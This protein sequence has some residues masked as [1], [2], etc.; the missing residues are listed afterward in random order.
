MCILYFKD[1]YFQSF[2]S[3][4]RYTYPTRY[5]TAENDQELINILEHKIYPLYIQLCTLY[6]IM[7]NLRITFHHPIYQAAFY[8]LTSEVAGLVLGLTLS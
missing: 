6:T 1:S 8:R 5:S 7:S 2:F 4:K 3:K